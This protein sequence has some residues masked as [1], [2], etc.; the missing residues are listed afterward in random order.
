VYQLL[1]AGCIPFVVG[2]SN[3]QSYPNAA[4]L[5]RARG[6]GNV[7][8]INIDAHL[9]VRPLKEG[10]AH[11]GSP[12]R[13]MLEDARFKGGHFIEFAAQGNQCS[14]VH[15]D[16]ALSKGAT[17]YWL[18]DIRD[19]KRQAV[20]GK[21]EVGD[22]SPVHMDELF[23]GILEQLGANVFVSFDIDSITVCVFVIARYH[24]IWM[25]RTCTI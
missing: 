9:D 20:A 5:L 2:G 10:K 12:F 19:A 6:N 21:A 18:R 1:T 22:H 25:S 24:R 14:Q 23:W 15:A 3:D 13:L 4:A 8:T 17:I 11:S 7:G 16:Y